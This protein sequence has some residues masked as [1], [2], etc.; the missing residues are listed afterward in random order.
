MSVFASG[1]QKRSNGV[2]FTSQSVCEVKTKEVKLLRDQVH[3]YV[4][5]FNTYLK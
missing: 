5:E 3:Q 1:D 4:C 2:S